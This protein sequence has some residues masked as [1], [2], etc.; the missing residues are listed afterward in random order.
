MLIKDLR[1]YL[2]DLP[3]DVD[4]FEVAFSKVNIIDQAEKTWSREDVMITG[5]IV[6]ENTEILV[7]GRI[8]TIDNIIKLSEEGEQQS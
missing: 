4:N 6:D 8:E 7:L 3:E 2:N 5:A 1:K